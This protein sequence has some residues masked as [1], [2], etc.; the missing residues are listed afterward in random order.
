MST[1][2]VKPEHSALVDAIASDPAIAEQLP[3]SAQANAFVG[4]YLRHLDESETSAKDADTFAGLISQ[5]LKLGAVRAPGMLKVALEPAQGWSAGASWVLQCVQDDHRFL[6]DTITM[7]VTGQGWEVRELYHPQFCLRRDDAGR[8]LGIVP[9]PGRDARR[10]SWIH[11]EVFP[12]LGDAAA[13]LAPALLAAVTEAL[14]HVEEAVTDFEAMR[15][16]ARESVQDMT[17]T[18]QP[19]ALQEVR[20]AVDLLSWLAADNF[21]FLGY[22]EYTVDEAGF[23]PVPGTGLGILRGDVDPP[24]T[25]HAFPQTNPALMV[26]TKDTRHSPVHRR[27]Y[28]DYIGVRRFD[29]AGNVIGERRFLGLLA[30]PA[31][32]DSVFHIPTLN[33][34]AERMLTMSG[35]PHDSHGYAL[36]RA[37]IASYPRDELFQGRADVLYPIL[38]EVSRLREHRQV[39]L[40]VRPSLYGHFLSCT[41]YLPRDRYTT[42]VRYAIQDIL[43]RAVDGES[44]EYQATVSESVLARL[45][46]V[47]RLR[48]PLRGLDV[49]EIEAD[50]TAAVRNW[51]DEFSDLALE[52]ASEQRGIEF[53]EGYEE[54]YSPAQGIADLLALN[55]LDRPGELGFAMYTPEDASDPSDRRLKIFA[56]APLSLS[57]TMPHLAQLGIDVV[58]ERPYEITLR[59]QPRRIYDFGLRFPG[60]PAGVAGW[61]DADRQRFFTAFEASYKGWCEADALNNLVTTAGLGWHEVAWLRAISR[62]LQQ[63]GVVYGQSYIAS[64]LVAHPELSG[65]LV[66]FFR[67]KFDPASTFEQGERAPRLDALAAEIVAGLDEVTSLDQDRI[68]RQ[69]LAVLRAIVRTNAYAPA[70]PALAFK[71]APRELNFCPEPK[72]QHEIFVY[73]PRVQGVHLRF[74]AVAR[75][76]LRWSDRIEDFRTE[77][78]GLVKAQTVKNTVI[79]PVGAKGGFV[80]QR[81]P[82]PALDRGAW[83]AEGVACYETF[84][85][86]LLTLTDNLESGQVVPPAGVV[87][88]DG[89][90]PYLVV[91]AD[92]GTASFS[93]TA[94]AISVGRGFWL[95][96]AFASGGSAGYDHKRMGITARGA[97]ESTKRHFFEMGIDCQTTDFT[98]VGIGDMAG[99]V[100][101]N[102]MLLSRHIRLVAAFNHAHI[103]IDPDPDAAASFAERERLFHLPRSSWAD[104]DPALISPGGGVFARSL[105]SIP[106]SAQAQAVLGLDSGVAELTPAEL[107]NAILKAPVDLIYNGGIGTYVKATSE[108]H[109]EVGDKA[110]NAL[111]VNGAELRARCVVEGGNLGCT[112]RGRVEYALRGGRINTDF[113]DNSAGVDTSDHEVN[114]KIL[115]SGPVARGELGVAERNALLA[116]MTD[117]VAAHV[118]AHNIDQNLALANGEFRAPETAPAHEAFMRWL[119]ERHYLDRALEFLPTTEQMAARAAEGRGLTRPELATL[120]AYA[121]IMLKQVIGASD[122]PD[123][124]YLADRL[125]TYFPEP[126]RKRFA[127]EMASHQLRREIITTVAVNRFVNSQGISAIHRLGTETSAEPA[128]VFRAQLAARS[129]FAVG[130]TELEIRKVTTADAHTR[131]RI[132][133]ALRRMVERATRWLLHN[134]RLPLD[135]TATIA[136]LGVGVREVCAAMPDLVT[137]RQAASVFS[138]RDD[139]VAKGVPESLAMASAVSPFAHF[140]LGI[141]SISRQLKRDLALVSTT[142]FDLMAALGI[143]ALMAHIDVLPRT[144]R[145]DT[146]A[147]AALRDD[148]LDLHARITA[149]ALQLSPD[150]ND[151]EEIIQTWLTSIAG[152]E[153][154][155]ATLHQINA[156]VSDLPHLSVA[157][158][159]VRS[160]L[161]GDE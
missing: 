79:V 159:L 115:L 13:D 8:L 69:F 87:R 25:F 72:P 129:I 158:R 100:F 39:R 104:Y 120:L 96:D 114:I 105:K 52:L 141:V 2:Q 36:L 14:G 76:G 146:M 46:F 102:G 26:M 57:Q 148:L 48:A 7:T 98:C 55:E 119:E 123:D 109:A 84:V 126:L 145:W 143:D 138:E 117:D 106:V 17:D 91:A 20:D 83:L 133:M 23:T 95:G 73:S 31:Y 24:G 131:T 157:L 140:A 34:K 4:E 93:D 151:T 32:T 5:H 111:R 113:I 71:L 6:V 59:D 155:R 160:L 110:N 108:S 11:M 85:T 127:E 42:Q 9:E 147:R 33:A 27:A 144:N 21:V 99:D 49:A 135:I 118:L 89:D 44:L 61:S 156:E 60:G 101:G 149:E 37:V 130:A 103:F 81:L 150:S 41:I 3:D 161:S 47:V 125:V 67:V 22:R 35:Y 78:L 80:P 30:A 86:S 56:E 54:D 68:I 88:Y 94:N 139:L 75:G 16:R 38:E 62:Y 29:R 12:P 134:R 128:D 74:G 51:D 53:S 124:P 66:E 19:V 18:P 40:F 152:L 28:L 90:D 50:L 43:L 97:W 107:I 1:L 45:F 92:K 137:Q 112:Q 63:L 142:Y 15:Q 77:V 154:K 58:D 121:K 136:A 10:E 132:R 64:A 82:D 153:P 70:A 65:R 122:L 116:S